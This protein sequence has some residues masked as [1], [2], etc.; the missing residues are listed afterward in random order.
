MC[1]E[2]RVRER[3]GGKRGEKWFPRPWLGKQM[4]TTGTHRRDNGSLALT[5]WAGQARQQQGQLPATP[6]PRSGIVY[7]STMESLTQEDLKRGTATN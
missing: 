1:R 6:L 7:I 3:K 5:A 4:A 2:E